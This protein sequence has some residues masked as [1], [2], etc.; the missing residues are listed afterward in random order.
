MACS[1]DATIF[2]SAKPQ[3]VY[4]AFLKAL[5]L[6]DTRLVIE[7]QNP[8]ALQIHAKIPLSMT[9]NPTAIH[10]MLGNTQDGGTS[11]F[12]SSNYTIPAMVDWGR[13]KKIVNKLVATV[14][15]ILS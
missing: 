7:S 2:F 15:A 3:A 4:N 14:N 11:A 13:N 1:H 10:V 8:T 5:P 9:Y 6:L 12:V